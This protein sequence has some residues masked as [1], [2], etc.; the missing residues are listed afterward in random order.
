MHAA[1][2]HGPAFLVVLALED[3]RQRRR[4]LVEGDV[5]DEAEPALVD[6]DQRQTVAREPAGDAEHGAVAADDDG[7]VAGLAQRLGVERG[8]FDDAG[9]VRGLFLDRDGKP[10]RDQESRD[11]AE[12]FADAA[13]VEFADE[14]S[15]PEAGRHSR[16]Y[17]TATPFYLG[18]ARAEPVVSGPAEDS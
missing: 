18:G 14:R 12:L 16:D 8:P 9:V 5:G 1:F 11:R 3:G 7:D 15:V 13:G 4:E 10:V 17:T 2:E 6:A